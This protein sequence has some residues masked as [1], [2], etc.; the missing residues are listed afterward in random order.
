MGDLENEIFEKKLAEKRHK[1][2]KDALSKIADALSK[3]TDEKIVKA[4]NQ[5]VSAIHNLLSKINSNDDDKENEILSD[6]KN[7]IENVVLELKVITNS[8]D[9]KN[10]WK[11]IV[12]RNFDGFIESVEVNQK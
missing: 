2:L 12:N 5:Q 7:N 1:E 6:V 3:D 8:L 11:F 4:I 9:K 10:N